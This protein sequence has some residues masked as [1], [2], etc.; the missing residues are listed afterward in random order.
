VTGAQ[1]ARSA[2][3]PT[4]I[5][6]ASTLTRA[7]PRMARHPRSRSMTRLTGSGSV[8]R[9]SGRRTAQTTARIGTKKIANEVATS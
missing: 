8:S 5:Q 4:L 1:L 7:T 6:S 3:A 2:P 9:H